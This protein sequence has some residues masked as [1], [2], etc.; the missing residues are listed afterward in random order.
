MNSLFTRFQLIKYFLFVTSGILS[1]GQAIKVPKPSLPG[2]A[3]FHSNL[4]I[5]E[6]VE[7]GVPLSKKRTVLTTPPSQAV[8]I[9][10]DSPVVIAPTSSSLPEVA[11]ETNPKDSLSVTPQL[12]LRALPDIQCLA[13]WK[14]KRA[15]VS[16]VLESNIGVGITRLGCGAQSIC[17]P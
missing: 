6:I 2:Y 17:D 3:G 7:V 15:G 10:A 8:E 1:Y 14:W 4:G 9:S 5:Q 16:R 13:G 12:G 11:P